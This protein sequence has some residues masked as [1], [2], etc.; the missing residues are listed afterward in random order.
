[1]KN[2][3]SRDEFINVLEEYA[4]KYVDGLYFE[5]AEIAEEL[6]QD[7]TFCFVLNKWKDHKDEEKKYRRM[8]FKEAERGEKTDETCTETMYELNKEAQMTYDRIVYDIV[9]YKIS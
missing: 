7:D 3:T 9:K 5:I 2:F 1:M 8:L 4:D 6:F